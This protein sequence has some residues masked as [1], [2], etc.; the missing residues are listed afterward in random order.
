VFDGL[1]YG[2][3]RT[4]FVCVDT[5]L[6]MLTGCQTDLPLREFVEHI[7]RGDRSVKQTPARGLFDD[8]D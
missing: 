8:H 3:P 7:V 2:V 6:A 1:I 5:H 4:A